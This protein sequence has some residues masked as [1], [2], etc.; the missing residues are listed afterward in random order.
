MTGRTGILAGVAVVVLGVAVWFGLLT[1]R[2]PGRQPPLV[3]MNPQSLESL[4]AQFNQAAGEFRVIL[5]L[6]PT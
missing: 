1:H 3:E 2:T 4:K 5:L 6:S